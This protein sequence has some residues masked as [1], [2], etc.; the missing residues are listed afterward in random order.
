MNRPIVRRE[1]EDGEVYVHLSMG[2]KSYRMKKD[3][4]FTLALALANAAEPDSDAL[5]HGAK[6][7]QKTKTLIDDLADF[8]R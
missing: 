2:S 4:A 6:F 8:F 5:V 1:I 3:A 7:A